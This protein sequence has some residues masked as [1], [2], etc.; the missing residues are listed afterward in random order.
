MIY[1]WSEIRVTQEAAADRRLPGPLIS[2]APLIRPA[3][4]AESLAALFEHAPQPWRDTLRREPAVVVAQITAFRLDDAIMAYDL[5]A[6]AGPEAL[7][8]HV[9]DLARRIDDW[10]GRVRTQLPGP[11]AET[12]EALDRGMNLRKAVA[13][14]A[15]A[16]T[17]SMATIFRNSLS[18]KG[19]TGPGDA[20]AQAKY[21]RSWLSATHRQLINAIGSVQPTASRV[22]EERIKAGTIEPAIGLLLAELAAAGVVDTRLNL[23]TRRHTGFYYCDILGQKPAKA[24]IEH[25]LLHLPP[26]AARRYLPERTPLTARSTDGRVERFATESDLPLSTARV[27]ATAG[28][29]YESD[30]QVSL[31]TTLGAVT[32]IRAGVDSAE[33]A[34]LDRGL[35][36]APN[37]T[38]LDMGLDIASD[39]FRLREGRRQIELRLNMRKAT[40]LRATSVPCATPPKTEPDPHVRLELQSDPELVLACGFASLEEGIDRIVD[41]V[42][43]LVVSRGC[44]ASMSLIY[45]AMVRKTLGV[46]PLRQLL[47]RIFT[48]G[49]VEGTPWPTGEYWAVLKQR[50]DA[51]QAALSGQRRAS[52]AAQ[53]TRQHRVAEGNSILGEA[54]A[55]NDDGSFI[56]TPG[57]VFQKFLSDAFTVTLSTADGPIRPSVLQVLPNGPDAPAGLTLRMTLEPGEPA[58]V[59]PPETPGAAP[60]LSLRYAPGARI[61]PA[62]FFERYDVENV[63]IRVK[64]ADLKTLA[65]F[66]DDGPVAPDQSFLPFTS[67]PKDG[68]TL[69]IASPEM[70]LKPIS[71]V[72]LDVTWADLPG[73][74]QGFAE[75]YAH[76]PAGTEIP[77]PELQMDYL[78][79]GKWKRLR[80]TAMPLADQDT[81]TGTFL[82]EWR[83]TGSFDTP[84]IPDGGIAGTALAKSRGDVRGGAVRLTLL[85]T[86]NGFGQSLYPRALAQAMRP[87]LIPLRNRPLPKPPFVPR[88]AGLRLAYEA[89]ATIELSAPDSARPRDKLYQVTP[90]ARAELF[91]ERNGRRATLFPV[92]LGHASLFIKI[93]GPDANKRLS[94]LFDIADSGHARMARQ[95]VPLA[96]HYLTRDGWTPLPQTEI[97][98]DTT[99][100][101]LRSGTV[102]VDLPDDADSNTAIMPGGGLWLAVSATRRGFD[103]HPVLR[104]VRTNGIWVAASDAQASDHGGTRIWSFDPGVPGAGKPV[105]VARRTPPRP[106]EDDPTFRARVSERL[107]H[108]K[109]AVTPWDIERLVLEKFPEVWRVK[110]LPHLSHDTA[111]PDPGTA[112]VAVVRRPP[113]FDETT[114]SVPQE[115]LFDVGKLERINSFIK[116]HAPPFARY[117]V[118]NPGFDI[119]HVRAKIRFAE[120]SDDGALAFR[121]KSYLTRQLSVWTAPEDISRFGW[122]LN[123]SLLRAR[124]NALSYIEDVTDFSVLHFT[125]DDDGAY[126]LADTAQTDGRGPH[127]TVIR[128]SRPWAL[129]LSARSHAITATDRKQN[130]NPTQSGIG[131]LKVGEM[132]VVGQEAKL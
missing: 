47:G 117:E 9:V 126:Q 102:N 57:D 88:I 14:M 70:A 73:T 5:A 77:A 29:T 107:R 83:R 40:P 42:Q 79:G 30:P 7:V 41:E 104:H 25:V 46:E 59:P 84:V 115:L 109:R 113:D 76:Y 44:S 43:N 56:F 11:F 23:F 91:P 64:A 100:G 86:A 60:V 81:A 32:G 54:F 65:A 18:A 95:Q 96:W 122:S 106:S 31:Y 125:S 2:N 93:T 16:T 6:E 116:R 10:L 130:I 124:I 15:G 17:S 53:E 112:T 108:R 8:S 120:Y 52:S 68:S 121:L 90:F 80:D 62:S 99:D 48:L 71:R 55:L 66:T 13:D 89:E 110:C 131:R 50:I 21:V 39:M 118:V 20:I 123:V 92:R 129:A 38:P 97:S 61:C 1:N 127:G 35:F 36:N 82:P 87:S 105:E 12:L 27:S 67:R 119:L 114:S 85:G 101:L 74:S 98:S 128:P 63:A 3:S 72:S 111:A 24:A 28:I 19:G 103:T 69:T 78:S 132:L 22:F 49:L 75:H 4:L 26:A 45:E 34:P 94:L 58:I 33:G 51:S 37:D